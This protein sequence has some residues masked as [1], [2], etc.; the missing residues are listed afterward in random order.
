MYWSSAAATRGSWRTDIAVA[1]GQAARLRT[2]LGRLLA[3]S[4]AWL[5]TADV[6]AAPWNPNEVLGVFP[7]TAPS[8][9]RF[10][11]GSTLVA[12]LLEQSSSLS[13]IASAAAPQR[14]SR[15]FRIGHLSLVTLPVTPTVAEAAYVC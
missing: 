10:S 12:A 3:D 2:R 13:R 4:N 1:L 11:P 7:A 6:Q 5:S 15:I 9:A 14:F 8:W